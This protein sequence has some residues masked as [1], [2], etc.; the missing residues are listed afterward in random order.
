MTRK[1]SQPLV[2]ANGV[3]RLCVAALKRLHVQITDASCNVE[4]WQQASL[5][6]N[7]KHTLIDH[8]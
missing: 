2:C 4:T 7:F 6:K 1:G 3:H 8:H 5:R